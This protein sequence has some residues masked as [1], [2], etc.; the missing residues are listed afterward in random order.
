M[1]AAVFIPAIFIS[2]FLNISLYGDESVNTGSGRIAENKAVIVGTNGDDNVSKD[3]RDTDIRD[4]TKEKPQKKPPKKTVLNTGNKK[5]KKL[6]VK[7]P[8]KTAEKN[9]TENKSAKKTG[10][11]KKKSDRKAVI[12]GLAKSDDK[13]LTLRDMVINNRIFGVRA[14]LNNPERLAAYDL[15]RSLKNETGK[16]TTLLIDAVT[17]NFTEMTDVLLSAGADINYVSAD[18]GAA[19]HVAAAANNNDMIKF[20][21]LKGADINVRDSRGN[22]PLLVALFSGNCESAR[23]LVMKGADSSAVNLEGSTTIIGAVTG[24]NMDCIKLILAQNRQDLNRA[25][26][27]GNT[28]LFIAMKRNDVVLMRLLR[29]KGASDKRVT[30]GDVTFG[31]LIEGTYIV[32]EYGRVT[33]DTRRSADDTTAP[34]RYK[35]FRDGSGTVDM[36]DPVLADL[37]LRWHVEGN[38]VI[39]EELDSRGYVTLKFRFLFLQTEGTVIF[40]KSDVQY[41]DINACRREIVRSGR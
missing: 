27:S 6:P 25:D 2:F 14:A 18:Y 36:D 28:P 11:L 40:E 41:G 30:V 24:G 8:L 37:K 32:R 38:A 16:S 10:T 3:I 13:L 4:L 7:N 33:S 15:D 26:S 23:L 17:R 12:P 34:F 1:R 31:E 20:L 9:K 19:L 22:T 5:E 29:D 35:L 21:L 39:V